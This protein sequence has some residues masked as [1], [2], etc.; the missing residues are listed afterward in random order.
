EPKRVFNRIEIG[1]VR[2]DARV[3]RQGLLPVVI[4]IELIN[5][6]CIVADSPKRNEYGQSKQRSNSEKLEVDDEATR[7]GTSIETGADELKC[8]RGW[9]AIQRM[10]QTQRSAI[11]PAI[12]LASWYDALETV[13]FRRLLDNGV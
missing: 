6:N 12:N 13:L 1:S 10:R 8:H 4:G 9:P 7:A 11:S 2:E 3:P 5:G